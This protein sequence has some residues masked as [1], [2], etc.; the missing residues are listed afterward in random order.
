MVEA[1]LDMEFQIKQIC[2][3]IG[4]P[5]EHLI[6]AELLPGDVMFQEVQ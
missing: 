1:V 2:F 4:S 5:S 6:K 3:G